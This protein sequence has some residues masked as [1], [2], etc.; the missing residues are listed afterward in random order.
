[1]A[2]LENFRLKVFRAVAEHLNF[3]K[4]AEQL[5]LTQPAVTLQIKALENDLGMRL[6]DRTGGTITFTQQGSVLL[7]YADKWAS[8][9]SDQV[10]RRGQES[11]IL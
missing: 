5:F 2:H 3:R 7:G 9:A 4:A 1:M 8:L 10:W 6:F 11:H